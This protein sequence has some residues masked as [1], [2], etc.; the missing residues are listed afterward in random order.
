LGTTTAHSDVADYYFAIQRFD[1]EVGE[2]IARL[3]AAGRLDN[4]IVIM[5]GDNGSPFP[6]AKAT[7]YD[8]GTHV[9]LAVRW[10]GHIPA[11]RLVT[12]FVSL[13]DLAPTL[14][15]ATGQP[16]PGEMAGRSFLNVLV[17]PQTGRTDPRR[18]RVFTERERHVISRAGGKSYPIR[19]LRIESLHYV[20]NLRPELMPAGDEDFTDNQFGAFGDIDN[21]PT[22][23]EILARRDEPDMEGYYKI[24]FGRR[25]AEELFD[26]E[27]DPDELHNLAA[28][29]AYAERLQQMR[30]ELDRWMRDTGDP[31]AAGE[32]DLWD[33]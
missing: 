9:P 33:H 19:S 3:E 6:R 21:S 10:P 12:D 23:S 13:V 28:H 7:C 1:R 22:K 5:T 32:T 24:A 27:R 14:L 15:E 31:R 2:L 30:A 18:D 25:P 26:L 20:R 16:V 4:T 8:A 11:G 17:S 29:P